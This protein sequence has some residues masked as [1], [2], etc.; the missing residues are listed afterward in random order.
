MKLL[1]TVFDIEFEKT[2][3]SW[4]DTIESNGYS[5]LIHVYIP[6]AAEF[7]NEDMR[8][9]RQILKSYIPDVPVIGCSSTGVTYE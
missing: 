1:Q 8:R 5:A 9:I 2:V 4:A 6:Y 7:R 3:R